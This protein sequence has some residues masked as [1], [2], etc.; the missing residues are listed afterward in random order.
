MIILI[1]DLN[2]LYVVIMVARNHS[3]K[4]EKE[5]YINHSLMVVPKDIR[6]QDQMKGNNCKN[7]FNQ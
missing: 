4:E 2:H 3:D 6:D 7:N 5:V 1:L